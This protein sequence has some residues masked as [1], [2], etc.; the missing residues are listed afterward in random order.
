MAI[1]E[2]TL[3]CLS[4]FD[5][6]HANLSLQDPSFN[7]SMTNLLLRGPTVAMLKNIKV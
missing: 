6:G 3:N 1:G 5:A 7:S 2:S 4:V